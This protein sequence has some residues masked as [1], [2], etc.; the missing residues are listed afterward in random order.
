[1]YE[2]Y[3]ILTIGTIDSL[4]SKILTRLWN[5]MTYNFVRVVTRSVAYT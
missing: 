4:E 3:V 1:M 2:G 5:F